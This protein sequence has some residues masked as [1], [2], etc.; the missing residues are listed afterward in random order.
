MALWDIKGKALKVSA[1]SVF[2]RRGAQLTANPTRPA[3]FLGPRQACSSGIAHG[4]D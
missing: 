2:R 1:A 4:R 3:G